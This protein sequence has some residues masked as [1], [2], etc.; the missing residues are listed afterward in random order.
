VPILEV[1]DTNFLL[2]KVKEVD[3]FR[4][5]LINGHH[6]SVTLLLENCND[7]SKSFP[8]KR[9]DWILRFVAYYASIETT[10]FLF[11]FGEFQFSHEAFTFFL[12]TCA[13][14]GKTSFL[15]DFRKYLNDEILLKASSKGHFDVV[16]EILL[17]F[18]NVK[19][20]SHDAIVQVA[21]EAFHLDDF[22]FLYEI[23]SLSN[24]LQ[25]NLR[26]FPFLFELFSKNDIAFSLNEK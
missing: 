20:F 13:A 17:I 5:V 4:T 11:S 21:I 8:Q 25:L 19:K 3:L 10:N 18:K 12:S 6:G 7:F 14:Q 15:L 22:N 23:L 26:S 24:D 2:F 9:L 1:A 16:K